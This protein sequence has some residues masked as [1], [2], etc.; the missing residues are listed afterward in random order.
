MTV[1]NLGSINADHVYSVPH[2]P[3]PVETLAATGFS[4]GLGGKGTN[5]S[6]AAA[7]AGS[8]VFHICAVGPDGVWA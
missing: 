7:R 4:I 6:V 1:F 3:L 5:Q 2:L 8:D